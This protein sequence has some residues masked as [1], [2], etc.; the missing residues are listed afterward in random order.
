MARCRTPSPPLAAQSI[1][2]PVTG[3]VDGGNYN[4][5]VRCQIP[6][7]EVSPDDY[8]IS[9]SIAQAP[10]ISS[11]NSTTFTVNTPGNFSVTTAGTPT[12]SLT[13]TGAL[14]S[15]VTFKDNGN[16]TATLSGAPGTGTAGSYVLTIKA[17]NGIGRCFQSF[18]LTVNN[19]GGEVAHPALR[20]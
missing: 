8:P 9:F 17:H 10:A 19:T 5:F 14:P 16:G 20:M 15:G 3:L 1:P 11:A 13:A 2:L 12:P 7:G 4:F 6:N 18:A